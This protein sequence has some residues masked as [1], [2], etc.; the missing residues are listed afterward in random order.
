MFGI[1]ICDPYDAN[2]CAPHIV[3]VYWIG[4]KLSEVLSCSKGLET[5]SGISAVQIRL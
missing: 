3:I 4:K 2:I 5:F 1:Y